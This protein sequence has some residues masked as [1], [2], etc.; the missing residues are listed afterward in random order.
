MPAL[1]P[2]LPLLSAFLI[3]SS[4]LAVTPGPGVLYIVTRSLSQG[5]RAGLTSVAGV[6]V[7]NLGNALG[8]S[9]GLAAVFSLS[10]P[11][12]VLVKYAGAGY[13][14]WLGLST[15]LG[16][17]GDAAGPNLEPRPRRMFQDGVFVALLNPKTTIFFASFLPQFLSDSDGMMTQT[18]IL[19]TI[20]VL[21]AA[22]TDSIYAI[23]AGAIAPTLKARSGL[24]AKG[25]YLT[26][27]VYVGLGIL[28]ALSGSR[29]AAPA[30]RP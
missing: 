18:V 14:T 9:L 20:F 11:A 26:G 1:L 24:A 19:G 6:A 17:T 12:F 2:P 3:A 21:L 30:K 16:P 7:G 27:A 8:A 25:R 23:A 28:T 22:A 13:L 10:P 4:I 29:A 15:W 5:R